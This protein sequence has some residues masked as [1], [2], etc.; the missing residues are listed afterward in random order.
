[1]LSGSR[2]TMTLQPGWSL[3]GR[4]LDVVLAEP[5]LPFLELG[6][7]GAGNTG[8]IEPGARFA[9]PLLVVGRVELDH[10]AVGNHS[11]CRLTH[12]W[13]RPDPVHRR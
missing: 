6:G 11:G 12:R 1:M 7:A 2:E 13:C 9:E 8:V 3:T 4:L 10:G 5:R